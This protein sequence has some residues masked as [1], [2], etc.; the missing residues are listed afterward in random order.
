[1]Y[2]LWLTPK[3][4]PILSSDILVN[5][6]GQSRAIHA[7]S[8]AP[9]RTGNPVILATRLFAVVR[10]ET[11]PDNPAKHLV[12]VKDGAS[13]LVES[14]ATDAG[15][16]SQR[17]AFALDIHDTTFHTAKA[18]T[19]QLADIRERQGNARHGHPLC[20]LAILLPTK[21]IARQTTTPSARNS[22]E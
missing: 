6:H 7:V 20:L 22:T 5:R 16:A 9:L 13:G 17:T 10:L 15:V 21:I 12:A 11:A 4:E 18:L 19:L 1:M 3:I 2:P 8:T 14:D